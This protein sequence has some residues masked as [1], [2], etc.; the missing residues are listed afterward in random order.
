MALLRTIGWSLAAL[1]LAA[2]EP[3]KTTRQ[4]EPRPEAAP[5]EVRYPPGGPPPGATP[6]QDAELQVVFQWPLYLARTGQRARE[7]AVGYVRTD[8]SSGG[9]ILINGDGAVIQ[10]IPGTLG[11][12]AAEQARRWLT[13]RGWQVR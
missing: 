1:A 7:S 10:P 8:G 11:P 3:A 12:D 5:A 13:A 2:C 6:K 4:P 9:V